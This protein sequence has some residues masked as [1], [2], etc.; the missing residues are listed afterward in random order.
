MEV[1]EDPSFDSMIA[2][3]N[4][5][6]LFKKL[7]QQT[8]ETFGQDLFKKSPTTFAPIDLSPAPL[9]YILGPGDSLKVQFFGSLTSNRIVPVN[10]EGNIVLPE[11]GSIQVSGLTFNESRSKIES[12]LK[13]SLVGVSAEISLSKSF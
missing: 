8:F 13:A 5:A 9:E 3:Q 7:L 11:L 12:V 6:K 10:R 2:E 4:D 1:F